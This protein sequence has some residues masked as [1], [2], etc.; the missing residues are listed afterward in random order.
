MTNSACVNVVLRES[1]MVLSIHLS[2]KLLNNSKIP[3]IGH[4]VPHWDHQ[5]PARKIRIYAIAPRS[6]HTLLCFNS[7][8]SK[9][10][11]ISDTCLTITA[12]INPCDSRQQHSKS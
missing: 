3:H 4:L 10:Q 6:V 8:A 1:Y 5:Q 11:L 12:G 7:S 2:S 9:A